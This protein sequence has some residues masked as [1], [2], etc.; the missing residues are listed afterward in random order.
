MPSIHHRKFRIRASECDANG[1]LQ[2]S[3]YLR[4]M[5]ETAFDALAVAGY[6]LVNHQNLIYQWLIHETYV[7]FLKPIYYISNVNSSSTAIGPT[8]RSV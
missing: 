3:N 5:Q 6:D 2:S 4:F 8:T 1:H 7:R